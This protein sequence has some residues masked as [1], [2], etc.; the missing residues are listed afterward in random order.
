MKKKMF[1]L[2]LSGIITIMATGCGSEPA[3]SKSVEVETQVKTEVVSTEIQE[4]EIRGE[5]SVAETGNDEVKEVD[6]LSQIQGKYIELFPEMAK[7]EYR[8]YWIDA[9]TPILGEDKAEATTDMLLNMC[10]GELYGQEAIDAYGDGSNGMTFNCFFLG[11][12][13]EF[14]VEGNKISGFDEAGKEVFSHTYHFVESNEKGFCLYESDDAESGQFTFFSF[15]ADTMD[16]TYHLE[17]RYSEDKADLDSWF[18]GNYAYWNA[19][20]IESDYSDE[21][22]NDVITLF[23]NENLSEE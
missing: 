20:G 8:H 21:I 13:K 5:E 7:A 12:V 11:G 14:D 23:A 3:T 4:T 6:F 10:M 22:M 18:E 19:A 1:G 15:A 16:T 17:F 9:I 2:L